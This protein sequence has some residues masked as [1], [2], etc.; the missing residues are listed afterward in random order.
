MSTRSHVMFV[1]KDDAPVVGTSPSIY[2]HCDGY[3]YNGGWKTAEWDAEQSKSIPLDTPEWVEHGQL[4]YI[5]QAFEL[6]EKNGGHNGAGCL[7]AFYVLAH[8][9]DRGNVYI[10]NALAW[11]EEFRYVVSTDGFVWVYE[12]QGDWDSEERT[13]MG[14]L[15]ESGHIDK[16]LERHRTKAQ[17]KAA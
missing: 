11:D 10:Q 15:L 6:A 17:R 2:R 4:P 16:L 1:Y 7:A 9:E 8:K 3:P 12:V 13:Q 5:K 14:K